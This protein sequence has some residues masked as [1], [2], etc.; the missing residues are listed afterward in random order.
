VNKNN[1]H[2]GS[3]FDDFLKEDNIFEEVESVAIKRV[4]AFQLQ[5]TMSRLHMTKTGMAKRMHTSRSAI[6]RLFDP[7]N[8]A[9]TLTTLNRAAAA[10]GKKLKVELV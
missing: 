7:E 3:D 6:D 5:K 10:V 9:V 4:I 2:I 8:E 1:K